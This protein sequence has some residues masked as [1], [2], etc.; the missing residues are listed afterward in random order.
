MLKEQG[1]EGS[2]EGVGR[3]AGGRE[4]AHSSSASLPGEQQGP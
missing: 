1:N 2:E 3:Q 4:D